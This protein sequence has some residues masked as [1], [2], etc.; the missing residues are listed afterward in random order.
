MTDA[1]LRGE[2]LTAAAHDGLTDAAY[3][4][5]HNA[6]MHSA[7][8]GTDGAI[9]RRELRFLYPGPLD[10][11]TLDEIQTAGFWEPV[12]DGYQ[13]IGWA[14]KLGQSTAAE[15]EHQRA[16]NRAK[17]ERYRTRMASGATD[18]PG[19]VEGVSAPRGT[20]DVTGDVT[21]YVTGVVGQDRTGPYR[22]SP[23]LSKSRAR[24]SAARSES[25]GAIITPLPG[26]RCAPGQHRLLEDG[27][28]MKCDIRPGE[29]TINESSM[30]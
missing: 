24:G 2:W 20:G 3:R 10:Q 15:V 23:A 5:L 30:E 11:A 22:A 29:A 21:G 25:T 27:T 1:R 18:Q 12:A 17:Q 4:V 28:C 7:E 6:L 9:A 14:D 13:L 16:R 8:Q 19:D 26:R